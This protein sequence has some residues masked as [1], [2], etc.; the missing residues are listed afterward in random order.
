MDTPILVK[1]KEDYP[2][3]VRHFAKYQGGTV[4]C[5]NYGETSYTS[6]EGLTNWALSKLPTP[7][8]LEQY[9]KKA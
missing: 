4:W 1:S 9:R 2:W 7:E 8:E 6:R 3:M 5:W